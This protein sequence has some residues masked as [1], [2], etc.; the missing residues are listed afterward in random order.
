[1]AVFLNSGVLNLSA[2]NLGTQPVFGTVIG[3]TGLIYPQQFAV[4]FGGEG[5]FVTNTFAA[6]IGYSAY[7]FLVRNVI[8]RARWKPGN[9]HFTLFGGRDPVK[10]TQLSYAGERDPGQGNGAT[11]FSQGPIWGGVVQTGGGIRFDV[12]DE[13][14][15]LYLL[16]EG[17]QMTGYHVLENNKYD[18]TM[19][20]YF[21]VHVWPEYGSLNVGGTVYGEHFTYNER[22]ETYGNGGYFSPNVYFLFAVPV[23]FNGHYKE[24]LH[25]TINGS[26]GV[27]TFQEAEE[28]YYPLDPG[29]QGPLQATTQCLL[30]PTVETS[31]GYSPLN[32][33]TGLNYSI[34]AKMS[35]H[36]N[37]HWYIGAFLTGNNTNNYNTISGGFFARYVIRPQVQTVDYPTGLFP[38]E[39][40]RPVRVP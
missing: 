15:G 31:C 24:N 12:G 39:G 5:Q 26:V 33:N 10:E 21:R 2:T 16:G 32:S 25:Y 37:D 40:F 18:G 27:Q 17:A 29:L 3:S 8:G 11:A 38:I 34:D 7:G 19:G 4:G 9:G 30:Q 28:E 6:A 35:Y 36:I 22:I 13:K 23:T 1:M 20:A 14:S